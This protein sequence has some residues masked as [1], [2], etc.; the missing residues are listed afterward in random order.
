MQ[1]IGRRRLERGSDRVLGGVCSGLAD[2]FGFDPLLVRLVFG[3][4][5]LASGMGVVLYALLWLVM[6][7]AGEPDREGDVL[8]AGLRSVERDL[9]RIFG[10]GPAPVEAPDRPVSPGR[11]GLWLGALLIVAG[12]VLLVGSAGLLAWWDWAVLWPVLIIGLGMLVLVR[13]LS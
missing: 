10:S 2:R 6:P 7:E 13:R 5:T 12:A 3:L 9:R 11:S 1:D 4:L 8:R